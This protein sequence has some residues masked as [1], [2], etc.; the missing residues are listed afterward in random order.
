MWHN[1]AVSP[2]FLKA[3]MSLLT[4]PDTWPF[5]TALILMILLAVV[6]V[7]GMLLAASPSSLLDSLIPDVDGLGWLHVGR[8]PILV[9]VILW[10]TG[11]SLSGFAIQS[12][13]QSVTGAALPIWLASIPAVF[14]GLVNASLFGGVL[15]RLVPA[16][17]TRAVSEQSLVGQRGVVS[18]GM[19]R[20]GLAAQAKVRDA[21]G[22]MHYVLVEPL[23]D[24]ES[25][26]EG[27]VVVLVNKNGVHYRC[28]RAD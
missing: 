22:H 14:L 8:V 1:A 2:L 18:E 6:E 4:T 19:A 7:L 5:A 16:D 20:R 3:F 26:G 13:A 27:V 23:D 25:F 11:F 9:V 24:E 28:V 15:A 10:L 12:V 17:E 21:H